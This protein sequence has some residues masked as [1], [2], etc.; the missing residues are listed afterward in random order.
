M[1]I[2]WGILGVFAYGLIAFIA[3]SI[4]FS[5]YDSST[6][7]LEVISR[8][9]TWTA[10]V[11]AA[12]FCQ[13]ASWISDDDIDG[14]YYVIIVISAIIWY[15]LPYSTGA[16]ILFNLIYAGCVFTAIARLSIALYDKSNISNESLSE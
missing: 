1:F 6:L 11:V 16:V 7:T 10:P 5:F 13:I 3:K 2:L 9:D 14:W 12:L 4:I 8:V 15:N